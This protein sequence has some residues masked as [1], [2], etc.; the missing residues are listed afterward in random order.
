MCDATVTFLGAQH[1]RKRSSDIVGVFG[2]HWTV[3]VSLSLQ[4]WPQDLEKNDNKIYE[5]LITIMIAFSFRSDVPT[6]IIWFDVKMRRFEI[7][8]KLKWKFWVTM[9][10]VN[11]TPVQYYNIPT[12]KSL[13]E[14]VV[15]QEYEYS[16]FSCVNSFRPPAL[17]F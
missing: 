5:Q 12:F 13:P 3:L 15:T 1:K 10:F 2:R 9:L 11:D 7:E 4:S 6:A 16:H 14:H 8:L 17:H